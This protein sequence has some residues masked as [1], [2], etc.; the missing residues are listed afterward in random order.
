MRTFAF[1]LAA[2]LGSAACGRGAA[3][4]GAACPRDDSF[5]RAPALEVLISSVPTVVRRDLS[6][7]QIARLP[8]TESLGPGGKLQGITVAEH[9]LAYKS[10]VAVTEPL[11]GQKCAWIQKL[12][13]DL[14]P[15]SVVIYIPSEYPENSCE[16]EQIL[17]HERQ[18]DE[19]HRDTLEEYADRMRRALAKADWLPARGAPLAVS[20]REEADTRVDEMVEKITKPVYAEFKA[21]LAKRQAV[22]DEAENYRWVSRRCAHWK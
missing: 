11:F 6:L 4:S 14:T 13:V 20:G 12:T 15:R 8:G 17:A 21:E 2:A 1:L 9:Q 16:S 5:E 19:I 10:G 22:I 7:E 18:H 3:A